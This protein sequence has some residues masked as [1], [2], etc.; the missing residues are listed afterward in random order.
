LI[1]GGNAL[2]ERAEVL[3]VCHVASLLKL[4]YAASP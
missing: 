4:L 2:L 1:P 3:S